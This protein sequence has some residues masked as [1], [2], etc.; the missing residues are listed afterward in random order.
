MPR[1]LTE[2]E[3]FKLRG[4]FDKYKNEDDKIHVERLADF[5]KEQHSK[6]PDKEAA[7]LVGFLDTNHDGT[8]S[9]G[10]LVK[11]YIHQEGGVEHFLTGIL[12]AVHGTHPVTFTFHAPPGTEEVKLAG[13]FNNWIGEEM[14]KAGVD[15]FT[16]NVHVAEGRTHYKYILKAGEQWKWVVDASKPT[17]ECKSG[18]L[19]NWIDTN[20]VK[21]G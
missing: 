19:N 8:I 17:E 2:E 4:L 15:T 20:E 10:Q 21:H 9:Y 5:L 13:P 3:V 6:N 16:K 14:D 7:E 1:K 18:H 11:A 12:D